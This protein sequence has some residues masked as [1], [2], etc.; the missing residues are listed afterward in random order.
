MKDIY[1]QVE[2]ALP[3]QVSV[4]VK[5]RIVRVTGPRGELTKSFRHVNIDIR[6]TQQ[7]RLVLGIWHGGKKHVAC[8]RTVRSLIKNMVV[9]VT[10]GYR[11]KMRF[12]YAHFPINV[13]IS[14]D[15]KQVEIRNFLGE[16]VVRRVALLEGVTAEISKTQKDEIVLE[17]ISL[18]NVSQ[19]AASIQQACSVRNKDIRKFL[20]GIYVSARETIE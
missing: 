20:D 14:E 15:G 2:L 5:A 18:D 19:S 4:G 9:G 10:Q 3:P 7:R 8:L 17:G 12:V 13:S 1:K 6:H 11:Y 16:K